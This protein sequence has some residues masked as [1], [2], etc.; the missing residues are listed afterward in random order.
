MA[1]AE[2]YLAP[3]REAGVDTLVLGC[4]H[5][6]LLTG[7]IDARHGG[8][9]HAWS[10]APRRPPRTS[11][12]CSPRTACTAPTTPRRRSTGS[13]PRGTPPSFHALAG[14]FLGPVVGAV[15]LTGA[16]VSRRRA[17]T[18]PATAAPTGLRLTVVGCA[19]S[20]PG[21]ASAASCYLVEAPDGAGGTT[22]VRARP[23]QRRPSARSSATSTRARLDAVL[24]SHLHADHCLD[25]M[26]LYV[27]HRHHPDGP[28]ERRVPVR[29]PA[30]T[31]A[32][33][34][35]GLRPAPSPTGW[36]P[37]S[38]CR[39]GPPGGPVRVGAL[40]VTPFAVRHP[41]EAYA[42]AGGVDRPG[43]PGPACS[44][45]PATPTRATA[46]TP[47]RRGADL[48]LCEAA[49]VEGRDRGRGVHLTGTPRRGGRGPRRRGPARAHP[50]P[51]VEPAGGGRG[52]GRAGVRRPGGRR[53]APAVVHE[54]G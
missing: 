16:R 22:R 46:W 24:L 49:F 4:T 35:R 50:R 30:G 39:S 53:R 17:R 15:E 19:G 41:V 44:P 42:R 9:G 12:G 21:P 33:L 11:T 25:L 1:V 31:A 2:Q 54:V 3:V 8:A 48:L 10:P 26:G 51:G 45:T 5:Y 43:R 20:Y 23:G 37:S 32:R 27:M 18:S 47:R 36:P 13:S 29:G 28:A 6:P 40:A 52:G 14:R 34:A 7:V 38:T